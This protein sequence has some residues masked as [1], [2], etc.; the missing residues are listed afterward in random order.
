MFKSKSKFMVLV[1]IIAVSFVAFSAVSTMAAEYGNSDIGFTINYPD[2]WQVKP[3]EK[4][5]LLY[6]SP[7]SKI[8]W[9]TVAIYEK[10]AFEDAL[11]ASASI[12]GFTGFEAKPAIE[13]TT[14]DGVKALKTTT[15]FTTD[16]GYPGEGFVMGVKKGSQWLVVTVGTV[17]MGG[18]PYEEDVFSKIA[19]S[20]KF[21]K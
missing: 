8:P 20:L 21:N 4:P 14:D 2:A 11:T 7:A 10:A 9:I 15:T 17:P 12:S 3:S 18:V 13:T 19:K 1:L 5:V 16:T 6:A